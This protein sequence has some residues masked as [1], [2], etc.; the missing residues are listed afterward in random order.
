[1][2][3]QT[4]DRRIGSTAATLKTRCT[5]RTHSTHTRTHTHRRR[6]SHT[7]HQQQRCAQALHPVARRGCEDTVLA[8]GKEKVSLRG[9]A[10]TATNPDGGSACVDT[11]HTDTAHGRGATGDASRACECWILQWSTD[12]NTVHAIAGT[13]SPEPTE[14][15]SHCLHGTQE[16]LRRYSVDRVD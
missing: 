8:C 7:T 15:D 16:V 2:Q 11:V 13:R 4:G 5:A 6:L 3:A 10:S 12:Y 1:M 14:W 9:A